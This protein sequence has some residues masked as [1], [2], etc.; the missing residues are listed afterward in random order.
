MFG[1]F[2]RESLSKYRKL[3]SM[4][5]RGLYLGL[6]STSICNFTDGIQGLLTNFTDDFR[7]RGG[8]VMSGA[9]LEVKIS[10]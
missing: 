1:A 5:C 4:A 9:G 10:D 3:S 7:L 8:A 6:P 2:L